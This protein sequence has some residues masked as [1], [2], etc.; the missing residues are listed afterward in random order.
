PIDAYVTRWRTDP[1][2]R[3]SYSYVAV[4][5]TGA[6]YDILGEPVAYHQPGGT[7]NPTGVK[8][9]N[10]PTIEQQSHTTNDSSASITHQPRIFFAGEHT[11]RC[12]PATVHGALLSGLREAARIAN[13]YF[14]GQTPVRLSGFK[15]HT[16][17]N[18]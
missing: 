16:A 14:P 7:A 4:G 15:L 6:D 5:A 9:P 2:S 12:Y 3:G 10:N 17:Q 13:Y 8:H 1:Y 18:C 11:C